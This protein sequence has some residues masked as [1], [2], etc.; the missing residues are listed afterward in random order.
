MRHIAALDPTSKPIPRE[1]EFK[2]RE[3][4]KVL[5]EKWHS[6]LGS[7]EGGKDKESGVNGDVNGGEWLRRSR[8]V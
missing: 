8:Q 4:A 5:V 2:F 3:R 1:A 7:K 6:I